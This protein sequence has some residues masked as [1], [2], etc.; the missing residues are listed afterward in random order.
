MFNFNTF[1]SILYLIDILF[2]TDVPKVMGMQ[3]VKIKVV[4]ASVL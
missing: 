1:L 4:S 2:Y 3:Y